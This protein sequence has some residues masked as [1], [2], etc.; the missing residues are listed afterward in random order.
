MKVASCALPAAGAL[1]WYLLQPSSRVG[2]ER[3]DPSSRRHSIENLSVLIAH[4]GI[5]H[6]PGDGNY[7]LFCQA[8][9][10]LQSAMDTILQPSSANQSENSLDIS[11]GALSPNWMYSDYL[12]LGVDS[13]FVLAFVTDVIMI[14]DY[15]KGSVCQTVG[16]SQDLMITCLTS[17]RLEYFVSDSESRVIAVQ[18]T[19][20]NNFLSAKYLSD[21]SRRL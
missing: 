18:R 2:F 14:T 4:M 3:L 16:H 9:S 20:A 17:H 21:L 11:S 5:L 12:G 6:D 15:F 13:W 19:H 8:K 1:A 7:Q 10:A